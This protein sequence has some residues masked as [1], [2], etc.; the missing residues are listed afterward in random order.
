MQIKL[1]FKN[2]S[3]TLDRACLGSKSPHTGKSAFESEHSL[4]NPGRYTITGENLNSIS[5][6]YHLQQS[7]SQT[8]CGNLGKNALMVPKIPFICSMGTNNVSGIQTYFGQHFHGGLNSFHGGKIAKQ[9]NG[10]SNLWYTGKFGNTYRFSGLVCQKHA[11]LLNLVSLNK[12][13]INQSVR[14]YSVQDLSSK[15]SRLNVSSLANNSPISNAQYNFITEQLSEQVRVKQVE[16]VRL[17]EQR[18]IHDPK[19]YALQML[20]VRSKL[21]REFTVISIM[22]KP[23]SQ[24]TGVDGEIFDKLDPDFSSGLIEYLRDVIYHPSRYEAGAIR[25]VF[26]PKPLKSEKRPLGIPKL[27]DRSLQ[28]LLNL[29]LYPIVELKSDPNSYGFR[30]HRDSKQAVGALRTML[31]NVYVGKAKKALN[32]P[33]LKDAGN[34]LSNKINEDKWILDIKGFFDNISHDWLIN[35]LPLHPQ[36]KIFVEK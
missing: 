11:R 16:L 9:A 35:H 29:V 21:F 31:D 28:F 30:A 27:K 10:H 36:L 17:A 2:G 12:V 22:K 32:T 15:E 14:C 26:I 5:C 23:G 20:L 25:R 1:R 34:N 8:K 33:R 6:Q 3:P 7:N 19:V 18:G 4:I 24:T 13:L